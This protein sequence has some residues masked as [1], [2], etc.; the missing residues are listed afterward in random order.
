MRDRT[1]S[2]LLLA[3]GLANLLPGVAGLLPSATGTLYGVEAT[4]PS[5]ELVFRHRAVLL[6]LV[7]GG[8]LAAV[9]SRRF[10]P[11]AIGAAALSMS[12]FLALWLAVPG[13]SAELGRVAAVDVAAL[14]ALAVAAW[15]DNGVR[16]LGSA[17]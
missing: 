11:A 14:A 1:V 17:T 6:A 13:T 9:L 4:D 2:A 3:V 12:G 15:L 10:R 16:R 7:G 8:L 5:T